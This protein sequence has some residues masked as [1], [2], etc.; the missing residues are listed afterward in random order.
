MEIIIAGAGTVGYTLAKTLSIYH[1]ITIIDK[2]SKAVLK[3]QEDLDVLAV[4]GDVESPRTYANLSK[5][6]IDFFI[7]V[8]N[9]D[10]VNIISSLIIDDI[11]DV[12]KKIIRLRNSFFMD[13]SVLAKINIYKSI[14][15][16]FEAANSLQRLLEYSKANSVKTFESSNLILLSVRVYNPDYIGCNVR[17]ILKEFDDGVVV[18]GIERERLFFTPNHNDVIKGGDLVY[19]F[20]HKDSIKPQYGHFESPNNQNKKSKNCIIFGAD[21]LGIKIAKV[22]INNNYHLKLIEKELDLCE[23]ASEHLQDKAIVLNSRYG[24]GHLS[25]EEG[26]DSADMLIAATTDDEYNIIKCIEGKKAGIGRVI[27]VNNDSECYSLMHSLNLIIIRG[28]KINSYYSIL[29]K[30][31]SDHRNVQK[32]YC[33]GKGFYLERRITAHSKLI[34]KPVVLLKKFEKN[35]LIYL[36]RSE[37]IVKDFNGL[38]YQEDDI[39]S[40]F[41]E[42]VN[43]EPVKKW[44]YD[45]L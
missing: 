3:I 11:L 39:I 2:N 9:H 7:A 30:I 22:L 18:V 20:G 19:F 23:L 16:S 27:A 17:E 35:T 43:S 42:T 36:L 25:R 12:D 41:C 14:F 6:K 34:N 1:N 15:P 37:V 13:S 4:Y 40:V 29:E 44:L 45:D 8:T 21:S 38:S 31:N 28:E 32:R 5:K 24:W 33:G 26:L 10:E